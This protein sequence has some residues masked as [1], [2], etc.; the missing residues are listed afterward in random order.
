MPIPRSIVKGA[1]AC[2]LVLLAST[3]F[4]EERPSL[5]CDVGPVEK[6]FGNTPWLVYSCSDHRSIV[7]VSAANSPAAPFVFIFAAKGSAYQLHGEGTGKKE[8]TAAAFE[9]LKRLSQ[10]DLE[11]LL[12]QTQARAKQPAPNPDVAV[13]SLGE[14]RY[15]LTLTKSR[16]IPPE[17]GQRELFPTARSLCKEKEVEYGK[18]KFEGK[19]PIGAKAGSGNGESFVLKQEIRCVAAGAKPVEVATSTGK[20][21]PDAKAEKAIERLTYQYFSARDRG[22]YKDAY[23]LLTDSMQATTPFD[24]W[25]EMAEQFNKAA[26]KIKKREI[27]KITWYKDPPNTEPGVY[28]AVDFGSTYANIDIHCGYV[29]WRQQKDGSFRI[30]REEQNYI[31]KKTQQGMDEKALAAVKEKFGV[32]CR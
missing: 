28:A 4:S 11:S 7:V 15:R 2:I 5:A 31:D 29:A 1:A 21:S 18:Y 17:E 13:E 6:T 20:W 27:K 23:A 32:G 25:R 30:V 9:D 10:S 3:A 24:R 22:N 12:A 8:A 14:G 26:G 16:N 19:E